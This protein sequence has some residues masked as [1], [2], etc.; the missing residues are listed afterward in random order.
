MRYGMLRIVMVGF[1]KLN[2]LKSR[3]RESFTEFCFRIP[4][5][6]VFISHFAFV[7]QMH[8]AMPNP[9]FPFSDK[10]NTLWRSVVF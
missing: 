4:L 9:F 10:A 8:R 7:L 6:S 3:K 5:F 1:A 2:K